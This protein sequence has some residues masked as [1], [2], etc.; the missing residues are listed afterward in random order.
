MLYDLLEREQ[1]RI[2]KAHNISRSTMNTEQTA[3]Y[4]V[5]MSALLRQVAIIGLPFGVLM[6]L[7]WKFVVPLIGGDQSGWL[8]ALVFALVNGVG[9]GVTMTIM[10]SRRWKKL[11]RLPVPDFNEGEIIRTSVGFF[12]GKSGWLVL[13]DSRL[14]FQD[15]RTG[16]EK[17]S[18]PVD[19]I[20]SATASNTPG[21]GME[22]NVKEKQGHRRKFLVPDN[23]DWLESGWAQPG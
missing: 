2:C 23:S 13:S 5:P 3:R 12:K 14:F 7:Y 15:S 9:F 21:F 11:L 1:G 10:Q 16:T 22:L 4:T 18:V 6:G 8:S 19:Q 20:E 17:I